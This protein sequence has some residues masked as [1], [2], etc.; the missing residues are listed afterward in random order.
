MG[1]KRLGKTVVDSVLNPF[2][3]QHMLAAL[4]IV[5]LQLIVI[6]RAKQNENTFV[7][8]NKFNLI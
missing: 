2:K 3:L 7:F 5:A 6:N 1:F 8:N 4:L